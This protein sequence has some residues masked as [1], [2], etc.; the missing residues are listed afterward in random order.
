MAPAGEALVA[1]PGRRHAAAFFD[2]A[3]AAGWSIEEIP[4]DGLPVGRDLAA[5][6]GVEPNAGEQ[7]EDRRLRRCARRGRPPR[8]EAPTYPPR[9]RRARVCARSAA[10]RGKPASRVDAESRRI[11]VAVEDVVDDLEQH[12]ELLAERAPGRPARLGTSATHRP[13]PTDAANNLPVLSRWSSVRS[14]SAP[15]MS[16]Y[17]PPIIPS[18]APASSRAA[19]AVGRANGEP[20][21]LGEQSISRQQRDALS[22]CDVGARSPPPE[23]VVVERGQIVVDERERVD[24]LERRRSRQRRLRDPSPLPRSSQGR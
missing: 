24:E 8:P 15:V 13:R 12:S 6:S 4:A 20:E 10:S 7:A 3:R 17:C 21:G 14:S 1:D 5:V 18:V 22:E 9:S 19:A 11:A 2:G 16:R 23:V